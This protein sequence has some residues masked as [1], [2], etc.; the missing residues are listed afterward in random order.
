[1]VNFIVVSIALKVSIDTGAPRKQKPQGKCLPVAFVSVPLSRWDQDRR[2]GEVWK[3]TGKSWRGPWK[4]LCRLSQM[5]N[6][7]RLRTNEWVKTERFN[8]EWI[9]LK[10]ASRQ[11]AI[12]LIVNIKI[13]WLFSDSLS[14]SSAMIWT[15]PYRCT[16]VKHIGLP[17]MVWSDNYFITLTY[18]L[19][20]CLVCDY[21]S[22]VYAYVDQKGETVPRWVLQCQNLLALN[23]RAP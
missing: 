21:Q 11:M 1:M 3:K 12:D 5:E 15:T 4:L 13:F 23:S 7:S 10:I 8:E 20:S 19:Y 17:V 16:Y 2:R 18:L 14:L 6:K 22:D 9:Q